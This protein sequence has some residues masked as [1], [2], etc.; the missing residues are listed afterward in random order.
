MEKYL[1]EREK[2]QRN[3]RVTGVALVVVLYTTFTLV[4]CFNGFAYLD[5]PPPDE[6]PITLDLSEFEEEDIKP[7]QQRNGTRPTVE[8]PDPNR[9]T[10]LVQHSE[11]PVKGSKENLAQA[12][13]VDD[14]GDVETPEPPREEPIIKKALFSSAQNFADK[15]TLAPQTSS[16]PSYNLQPGH[17]SGNIKE[18]NQ[19]GQP[20]TKWKG[21][22]RINKYLPEPSFNSGEEGT[23]IVAITVDRSGKVISAKAGEPGTTLNTKQ[24][25]VDAETA[26]K[27]STFEPI[28]GEQEFY[29]GTITYIFNIKGK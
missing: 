21:K 29:Y 25:W 20:N 22:P 10:E 2:Q 7:K 18:G 28:E 12:S 26:A 13:T 17:A 16:E 19:S 3:S 11:A 6:S 15:D 27:N 4:L 23:V 24:A 8:E 1:R 14:I 9:Q 5:P